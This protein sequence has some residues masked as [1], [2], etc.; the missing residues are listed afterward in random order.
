VPDLATIIPLVVSVLGALGIGSVIGQWVAG[1]KDRRAARAAV[2]DKPAAVEAA[3]W[4]GDDPGDDNVKLRTA[5]RELETAA[6][7]ARVPRAAVVPYAQLAAAALGYMHGE[8]EQTGSVDYA[9][10]TMRMSD[11]IIGAAEVVSRAAW[12]PPA[13]RWLWLR[14][15]LRANRRAVGAIDEKAFLSSLDYARRTIR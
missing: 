13:V 15:A 3:R 12:S 14:R 6:L 9:G 8:V 11:T 7:L 4:V 2:L 5:I 1:G 10:I